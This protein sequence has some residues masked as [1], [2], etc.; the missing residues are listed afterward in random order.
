MGCHSRCW[1]LVAA[2]AAAAAGLQ[3]A[4]VDVA[5]FAPQPLEQPPPVVAAPA[6]SARCDPRHAVVKSYSADDGVAQLLAA[7]NVTRCA[8]TTKSYG[9]EVLMYVTPWNGRGYDAAKTFARKLTWV[10]PVWLQ[11]RDAPAAAAGGGS[12][13]VAITGTHDIDAGWVADVRAGCRGVCS[14]VP[15][16]IW[17]ASK[18]DV[19]GAVA[20]IAGAVR[21]H[22]FDGVVL[23]VPLQPAVVDRLVPPLVRALA[24]VPRGGGGDVG[25]ALILVV[26]PGGLQPAAYRALLAA[27]VT[28]FSVMTYDHSAHR[29]RASGPNA[30]LEWVQE[31][32]AVLTAPPPGASPEDA[33]ALRAAAL[34]G[35]PFYGYDNR[36]PVLG[37]RVAELL[38]AHAPRVKL[39]RA[40]QE[41]YFDYHTV[42][43]GGGDG[44]SGKPVRH[45][46][47]YPTPFSLAA[48]LDAGARYGGVA[49]W[50]GGQGWDAFFDLL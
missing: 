17:E 1:L 20:A 50:E 32:M 3:E 6:P 27:G 12:G 15:R 44:G 36:E 29:G 24:A 22:R 16:V 37:G 35:V 13:G 48:R 26:P 45:R 18:L 47:Y 43:E 4:A 40:A 2:G 14:I 11:L 34:V 38:A 28:R 25:C 23:E 46:V 30:P 8:P 39:D 5:G 10:S 42:P 49:I 33:V 31:T 19:D 9:A 21:A 41:H 7:H